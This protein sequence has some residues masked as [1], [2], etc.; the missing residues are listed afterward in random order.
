[1]HKNFNIKTIRQKLSLHNRLIIDY[2]CYMVG[3]AFTRLSN[4]K[5]KNYRLTLSL[6]TKTKE[7]NHPYKWR[8]QKMK[9]E[10]ISLPLA[11][12]NICKQSFIPNN[13]WT[14]WLVNF[15]IANN[16]GRTDRKSETFMLEK[17][18]CCSCEPFKVW[19][20][21]IFHSN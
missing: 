15:L 9:K 1:M 2:N 17:V 8:G 11:S 12:A 19:E 16:S 20:R 18:L 7:Q 3:L 14:Q 6:C 13:P 5:W 10:T 21:G 4:T